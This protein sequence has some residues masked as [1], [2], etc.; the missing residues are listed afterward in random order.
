MLSSSG[1]MPLIPEVI[2]DIKQRGTHILMLDRPASEMEKNC[3]KRADGV[4]RIVGLSRF[5]GDFKALIDYRMKIYREQA[6]SIVLLGG[7]DAS[8]EDSAR[9]MLHHIEEALGILPVNPV[10]LH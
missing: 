2:Q 4:S 9:I 7:Q 5:G 10:L 1:S 8:K 3:Q 6:D